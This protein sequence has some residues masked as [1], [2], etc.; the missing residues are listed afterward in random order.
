M[1]KF[2]KELKKDENK[3][4]NQKQ[5]RIKQNEQRKHEPGRL[6]RLKFIE[7]D[8]PVADSLDDLGNLRKLNP[9]GNLLMDRF[10]SLQK[11]NILPVN[12]RR[13]KKK[14]A[15]VTVTKRGYKNEDTPIKVPKMTVK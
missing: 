5:V 11:R 1:R 6:A 13:Q 14:R 12:K 3:L 2:K 15:L 10:K 4:E 9:E 8:L 7:E